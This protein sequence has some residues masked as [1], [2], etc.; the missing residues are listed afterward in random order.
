MYW[1]YF[2]YKDIPSTFT[3]LIVCCILIL[4]Y[5]E[6]TSLGNIVTKGEIAHIMSNFFIPH[7]D[8]NYIVW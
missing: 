8:F 7:N 1:K 5:V 6:Q 4:L 3:W 2:H